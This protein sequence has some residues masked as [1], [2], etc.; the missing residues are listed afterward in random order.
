MNKHLIFFLEY[1][2]NDFLI[3]HFQDNDF[4]LVSKWFKEKNYTF[5]INHNKNEEL[6]DY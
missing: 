5:T 1:K 6:F 4:E 2:Y 3:R